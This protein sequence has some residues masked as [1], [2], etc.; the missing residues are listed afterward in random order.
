VVLNPVR[1][2]TVRHP[3]QWKWSSYGATAGIVQPHGCLTVDE[4]LTHFGQRRPNARKKYSEY[5][6]AGIGKPS[7]GTILRPRVCWESRDLRRDSDTGDKKQKIREIPKGQRFV[8]QPSLEKLLSQ[9]SRGKPSRDRL[10]AES[11][12]A[13]GYSQIEVSSFLGLH[14]SMIS[15]ILAANKSANIKGLTPVPDWIRR[16]LRPPFL[17][18]ADGDITPSPTSPL[19]QISGRSHAPY[20]TLRAIATHRARGSS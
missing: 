6:Q 12:T 14:Y 2:K 16:G 15:R 20:C 7:I 18:P 13:H 1:A 10:V 19:R 5:V 4:I 11:V 17:L 8:G 3:R 9:R